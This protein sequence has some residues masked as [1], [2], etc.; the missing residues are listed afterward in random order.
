MLGRQRSI[1]PIS[2]VGNV[3][4]RHARS[5]SW[6]M[7]AVEPS[8][9][10][11]SQ[12]CPWTSGWSSPAWRRA[13]LSM[14][15]Y[16]TLQT[17]VNSE[18]HLR[19]WI[20]QLRRDNNNTPPADVWR[21]STTRGHTGVTLQSSMTTRWRRRRLKTILFQRAFPA[22]ELFYCF[23]VTVVLFLLY[24]FLCSTLCNIVKRLWRAL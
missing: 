6:R 15:V 19:A 16:M 5:H 11:C 21:R 10:W 9:I 2:F 17:S 24:C 20:D 1:A 7:E 18:N 8:P 23:V 12:V 3:H 13:Y 4:V 14:L 22:A